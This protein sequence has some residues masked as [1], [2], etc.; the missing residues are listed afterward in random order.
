M[1]LK[2]CIRC[3]TC[4][5][6]APCSA[7][8]KLTKRGLCEHLVLRKDRPAKCKLYNPKHRMWRISECLLRTCELVYKIHKEQAEEK[9]GHKLRTLKRRS[10]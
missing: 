4:C 8:C 5:I 9:V 3:G 6:I 2:P 10:A 1:R 7:D